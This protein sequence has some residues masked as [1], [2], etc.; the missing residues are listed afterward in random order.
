FTQAMRQPRHAT[1]PLPLVV[2]LLMYC[3]SGCIAA[4]P[5]LAH[6]RGFDAMM[7]RSGPLPTAVVREVPRKGQGAMQAYT[8][9][10]QDDDDSDWKPIRI[11][12]ST[13]ELE[14]KS[15]KKTYCENKGDKCVNVLGHEVTCEEGQVFSDE[16]KELYTKKILPGAVKLHAERLLVKPTGTNIEFPRTLVSPC[17]KFTIPTKHRSGGVP[18]ADFIIYAAAGPSSTESRAVWAATCNT[19]DDLRPSIGAMNFDPKYM[20]DTAWSVRVAA[21]E[22]AHALGFSQTSVDEKSIKTSESVVRGKRRRMVAGDQVKAKAQ[23]HFGCKTLEGMELEDEDGALA[24]K[25]PHWK[26][27]HARDELMAPTVGAGYYTALTMAVFADMGYYRVN[28]S[29]AEPMSWGNRSGC[30]FLQRSA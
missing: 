28:W 10:S 25:V 15:R 20:T 5:A 17:N 14:K 23:A 8:V 16:K 21:H 22:I 26:E 30:D 11:E 27:R 24:R 4:D 19:W 3:A 9:A 7:G 1:P 13:E 18:D 6:R 12:V 29:M 2:L